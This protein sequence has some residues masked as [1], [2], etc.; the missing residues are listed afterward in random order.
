MRH[1]CYITGTRADFGLM[2]NCLKAIDAHADLSLSLMVTG[3]HL[4][5]QHGFTMDEITNSGLAIRGQVPL[6]DQL[7]TGASMVIGIA[8]MIQGFTA[9]L[10]HARPD[11]LLL[12]GDR[13]EMLAGA[14]VGLHL[15]IPIVHIHG[16]E[17]SGTVD[18][19]I[20][21]AISKLSHFH[22]VATE[23]SQERLV[24]MGEKPQTIHVI[25]AP[26]LDGLLDEP[27]T[28]RQSFPLIVRLR[29]FCIIPSCKKQ[30]LPG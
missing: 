18:E 4:S 22:F 7:G 29:S 17:R 15:N 13:G 3:M 1:I 9:L 24:R 30:T 11:A 6:S 27:R 12:L 23:E 25:G 16:G 20:R 5:H 28:D 14:L 21:H 8:Q 26:G 2:T 19:P 10:D